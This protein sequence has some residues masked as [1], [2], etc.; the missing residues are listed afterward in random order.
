MILAIIAAAVCL[1]IGAVMYT[2]RLRSFPH[3][4]PVAMLFIFEGVWLLVDYIMRQFIPDNVFMS[5]INYI[6]LILLGLYLFGSIFL[7]SG[8]KAKKS[9]TP[10]KK[11]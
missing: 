11:P 4:R 2:P 1:A 5:V 7:L 8:K 10:K 3:Y 6:V 9:R